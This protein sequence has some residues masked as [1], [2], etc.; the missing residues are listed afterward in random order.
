MSKWIEIQHFGTSPSGKTWIWRV[1]NKRTKEIC[2]FIRWNGAFRKYCFY[3]TDGFL[4]DSDCLFLIADTM[5]G[6][7]VKHRQNIKDFK[8][9]Q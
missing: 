8:N 9:A 4:F 1:V 7:S 5:R 6:V 2:G 3:P